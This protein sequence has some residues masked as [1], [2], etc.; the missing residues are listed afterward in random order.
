MNHYLIPAFV[1]KL[2]MK[3]FK[4]LKFESFDDEYRVG[5]HTRIHFENGFGA[6]VVRHNS[7]YGNKDGLYEI[8][9]LFDNEIHYD[10]PVAKGDVIGYLTEEQVTEVLIEI[11]KL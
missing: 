2:K 10:N 1:K 11:Q 8:A 7:S 5:I 4:D 9:V 6:S 3:T